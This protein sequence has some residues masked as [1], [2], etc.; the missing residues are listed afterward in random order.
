MTIR[1]QV[2]RFWKVFEME[3][4]NL[5]K[6]LLEMDQEE[7]KEISKILST[8]FEE[9]CNC[10]LEI[11]EEDGIFE[12]TFLPEMEKNAQI[13]CAL[14][15]SM[16]PKEN[17]E[18][19]VIHACLPPLS[20]RAL[21]TILKIEND[22]Y[23]S[24]DFIVNYDIDYKNRCLN[25]EIYC[26]AFKRMR[27]EKARDVAYYMLELFVG[28]TA[29][30]GYINH[31][32]VL[33]QRVENDGNQVLMSDLYDR[34]LDIVDEEKWI[35]YKDPTSIYRVYQVSENNLKDDVRKDMKVIFTMHSHLINETL[36]DEYFICNQFFDFG[37]EYGYVYYEHENSEVND[38]IVRQT[39]EK[40]LNELLYPLGIARSIGGA[41]GMKYAY[42]D[43]ALF[44]KEGFLKA[45]EKI[46]KKLTIKLKYR[47]FEE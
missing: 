38:S 41:I 47:A 8:Y 34:L 1:Q 6:A 13:I 14:L 36:N 35:Q 31:V 19:W 27:A 5:E 7:V 10:E 12:I 30:E 32:E 37:G 23:T 15:K 44:D 28:E 4:K 9:L 2:K 20:Q 45:L 46:N 18:N 43:L 29:M 26:D 17:M 25:L 24:D 21:N 16:A 42:I 33:D 40:K 3:R 39:L 11:C 22:A